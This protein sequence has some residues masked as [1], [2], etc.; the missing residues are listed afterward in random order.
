MWSQNSSVFGDDCTRV[1]FP[2]KRFVVLYLES[3][4]SKTSST[5]LRQLKK[6]VTYSCLIL[7]QP[8]DR[9]WLP[10]ENIHQRITQRLW[11]GPWNK[12]WKVNIDECLVPPPS[13]GLIEA[14]YQVRNLE[15]LEAGIWSF[16]S[17]AFWCLL[18]RVQIP[19]QVQIIMK[20][21]ARGYDIWN[22]DSNPRHHLQLPEKKHARSPAVN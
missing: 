4:K 10:T 9:M 17:L 18:E 6:R 12:L 14:M 5:Q 3:S 1:A 8:R 13:H 19:G 15:T 16:Y 21:V 7:Q 20:L 2:K 11:A 22:F